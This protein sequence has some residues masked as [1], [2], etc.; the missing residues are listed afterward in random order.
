MKKLVLIAASLAVLALAALLAPP[1]LEDPGRVVIDVGR[2]RLEMS[3]LVLAGLVLAVWIGL[4]LV[5]ALIRLPGRALTK[6]RAARSRRQLEKG[7]LA[8][9]E[10][11]WPQAERCLHRAL[12]HR[13]STAG[14]L[15]AARAAEGQADA[16]GRDQ[17]LALADARFGRR[18]FVTGLARA[19]MLVG[20]G[21]AS[22]AID[23][24]EGLHLKKPSHQ[25]VLR[26]LLQAYQDAGRWRDLRLLTPALYKADIVD[27]R[28]RDE[29]AVHA[30]VR[31]IEQTEHVAALESAWR[32][33]PRRQRTQRDLILAYARRAS[34]LGRASLAGAQLKRLLEHDPDSEALRVYALVEAGDRPGR[35]RDCRRWLEA[36]PEH[37]GLHLALGMM[38]LD[39]RDYDQA[40]EHLEKA[41]ARQPDGEAYALLGRILDRSGRLEAAAQCYRNALR[42]QSGRGVEQLPPPEPEPEGG[43]KPA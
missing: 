30:G 2:W 25:G 4:A 31:E 6:A 1:L 12:E 40:R 23:V 16:A 11:D 3:A 41:V 17:W 27:A 33:L 21:R 14:Y 20:E 8:L 9:A 26:L 7:F 13:P 36:H 34:E 39:E 29:L 24:L 22:D 10:G 5:I 15:A 18:H 32:D 19:R 43:S 38:L 37:A 35:I 42:I 28:R